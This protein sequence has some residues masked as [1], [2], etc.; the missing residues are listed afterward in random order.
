MASK[1]LGKWKVVRKSDTT[2]EVE[3]PEGMKVTGKSLDIEDILEAIERYK[4]IKTGQVGDASG[5]EGEVT[6]KCCHGNTAIA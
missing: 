5:T 2:V 3:F 4:V 1:K 6:I